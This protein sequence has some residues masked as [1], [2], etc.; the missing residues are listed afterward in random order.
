MEEIKKDGEFQLSPLFDSRYYKFIVANP[1]LKEWFR[2]NQEDLISIGCI[3]IRCAGEIM[4]SKRSLIPKQNNS[5]DDKIEELATMAESIFKQLDSLINTDL[6]LYIK[7]SSFYSSVND[8]ISWITDSIMRDIHRIHEDFEN[9]KLHPEQR[10]IRKYDFDMVVDILKTV[11]DNIESYYGE[12]EDNGLW[13]GSISDCLTFKAKSHRPYSSIDGNF[14]SEVS[15]KLGEDI[16]TI[17]HIA[18]YSNFLVNGIKEN[19]PTMISI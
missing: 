7:N 14:Y 17:F 4:D 13:D 15:L 11:Y 8:Y 6:D 3:N 2:K 19:I 9:Y 16:L 12:V 18:S 1:N 10:V 5:E